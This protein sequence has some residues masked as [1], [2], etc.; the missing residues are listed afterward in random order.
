MGV[1]RVGWGFSWQ[2][3]EGFGIP[4]AT[5]GCGIEGAEPSAGSSAAAASPA[6]PPSAR[7]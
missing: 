6:S 1:G 5:P 2:R 3:D 4:G 7:D